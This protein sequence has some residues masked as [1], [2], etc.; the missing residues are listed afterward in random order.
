MTRRKTQKMIYHQWIP[1]TSMVYAVE[2][3]N[4]L[5]LGVTIV[6]N[7]YESVWTVVAVETPA[8]DMV[9]VFEAHSHAIVGEYTGLIE[10][11][12][13]GEAYAIEWLAR[14][15]TAATCVCDE[16]KTS[17]IAPPEQSNPNE[18]ETIMG[19]KQVPGQF[20]CYAN[21]RENEPLFVLLA[22]DPTAYLLVE[23]WADARERVD[24]P[25]EQLEEARAVARVMREYV[26]KIKGPT[27][28][29]TYLVALNHVLANHT[30]AL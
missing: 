1:Q 26:Y 14:E 8:K 15:G 23:L 13:A 12:N 24:G 5:R 6:S 10:A 25:S 16:I 27:V 29:K 20:D 19:T 21:A 22:R 11:L 7:G 17:P 3:T 4:G 2:R 30:V 9:G 28:M 18:M